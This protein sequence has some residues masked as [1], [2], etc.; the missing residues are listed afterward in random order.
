MALYRSD[1]ITLTWNSITLS[2]GIG[3]DSFFEI[4]PITAAKEATFGADGKMTTSVSANKGATLTLTLMQTA[5]TNATIGAIDAAES[6]V[7]ADIDTS[8]FTVAD[9]INN[10]YYILNNAVLT[11]RP[12]IT[13][14]RVVGE[15]QWRWICESYITTND[16]STI[17]SAIS[18]Y[19]G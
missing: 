4:A 9:S 8:I 13:Y 5:D 18:S 7:G 2:D 19:L 15:V 14:G 11:E 1:A 17:T 6:I 3:S 12:T 10:V 16:V